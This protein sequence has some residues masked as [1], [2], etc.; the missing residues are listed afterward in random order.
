[1]ASGHEGGDAQVATFPVLFTPPTSLSSQ[2]MEKL[3]GARTLL[4]GSRSSAL[5]VSIREAGGQALPPAQPAH[6]PLFPPCS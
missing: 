2:A 5:V 6:P 1:M 4:P 3:L